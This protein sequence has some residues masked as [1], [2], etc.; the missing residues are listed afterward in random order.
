VPSPAIVTLVAVHD[1][2]FSP[3]A[4]N[5]TDPVT[6]VAPLPNESLTSTDTDAA[7]F[8]AVIAESTDAEGAAGMTGVNVDDATRPRMSVVRK[9]TGV[10]VPGDAPADAVNVTTP[11]D[12]SIDH[13]PSLGTTTEVLHCESA[14]STRQ[15]PFCTFPATVNPPDTNPVDAVTDVK[16]TDWPANNIFDSGWATGGGGTATWT[17][18]VALLLCP[19]ESATTYFTGVAV[20]VK[21]GSGSKVTLPSTLAAQVPSLATVN[22]EVVHEASLVATAHTRTDWGSKVVPAADVSFSSTRIVW[23]VS[24]APL[25]ASPTTVGGGTT[26][27]V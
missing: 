26:E 13:V 8:H 1:G 10:R 5:L 4:H 11:V 15:G 24:Y 6:A 3:E 16:L 7:V 14:G 2:A 25:D 19:S 17:P 20:P 23:F 21:V 22:D 27:G 12:R 18:M 9:V